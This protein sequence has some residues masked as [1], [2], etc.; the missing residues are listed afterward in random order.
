M[1]KIVM[2]VKVAIVGNLDVFNSI[3]NATKREFTVGSSVIAKTA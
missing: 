2:S 1:L 3:V